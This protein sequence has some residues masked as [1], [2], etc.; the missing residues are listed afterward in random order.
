MKFV[1][2]SIHCELCNNITFMQFMATSGSFQTQ[3]KASHDKKTKQPQVRQ[4]K[5]LCFTTSNWRESL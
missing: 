4:Q 2:Y 3:P 1:Y 5:N